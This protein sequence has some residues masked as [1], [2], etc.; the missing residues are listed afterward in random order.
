MAEGRWWRWLTRP[1]QSAHRV[2]LFPHA[3][4]SAAYYRELAACLPASVEVLGVQYPGRQD[5]L[6]ERPID[7]LHRLADAVVGATGGLADVPTSLFGH[8]MGALVAFEAARRLEQ[9]GTPIVSLLASSRS[10]P[11][12]PP[13]TRFHELDDDALLQVTCELGGVDERVFAIKELV[14]PAIRADFAA[15]EAYTCPAEATVACPIATFAGAEDRTV[16]PDGLKAWRGHTTGGWSER[17]FPGGHFFFRDAPA[18]LAE[19][20]ALA[21]ADAAAKEGSC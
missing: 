7:D 15:A 19:A 4:G 14:A 18:Q 2:M 16:T 8:S 1:R 20:V 11:S 10:A 17:C 6:A 3:G 9:R 13:A 21:I 5:R 12:V